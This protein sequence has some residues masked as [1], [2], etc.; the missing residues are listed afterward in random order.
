MA[1]SPDS[2][3]QVPELFWWWQHGLVATCS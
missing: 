2:L 3:H 1:H